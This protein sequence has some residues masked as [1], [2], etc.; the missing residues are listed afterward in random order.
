M[1]E[2]TTSFGYW[3]RRQR[4]ALDLTQR[5]LA[6]CVGCST[7]TIKKIEADERRPSVQMAKRLAV[8]LHI[9]AEQR[10]RFL[11]V[12][13]RERSPD[14]LPLAATPVPSPAALTISPHT[15]PTTRFIGRERELHA[16]EARL[17]QEGCRLLTVTGLGGVGKTRLALHAAAA[18]AHHFADGVCVVPLSDVE[19]ATE[20][21]AVVL[22]RLGLPLLGE[23]EPLA[24]LVHA[25][26]RRQL[27]LVLDNGE[28]LVAD[29]ATPRLLRH[30]LAAAPGV[31]LLVTSRERLN[32]QEEWM[33]PLEGLAPSEAAVALFVDRAGQAGRAVPP[34]SHAAVAAICRVVE[35]LPLAVELAAG[36]TRLLTPE[37]IATQLQAT[38]DLLQT[39]LRD[40]PERHR[41]LDALFDQSWALLPVEEQAIWTRLAVFRGGFDGDAAARVAGADLPALLSLVDKSL[42]RADGSG[43]YDLHALARRYAVRR[44]AAAGATAAARQQHA[45]YYFALLQRVAEQGHTLPL[46]RW[47]EWIEAEHANIRAAWQWGL[48]AG[49]WATLWSAVRP[50]FAFWMRRGSWSEGID[51]LLPAVQQAP[52]NDF[53]PYAETLI[54][55]ATLYART[56]HVEEALPYGHEGYRRALR[57]AH[58]RTIAM[59]EM[60]FMAMQAPEA[61]AREVHFQAALAASRQANDHQLLANAL[62][63]YGDFLREQGAL[64]RARA[65]YAECQSHARATR[66]DGLWLYAFGNEGRLALLDGDIDQAAA[67][68]GE[69]VTMARAQGNPV[70][71]ADWLLRLG[72]VQ[73]YQH[74][75]SAAHLTL[76]ECVE[77]AEE[78]SHQHC[79]T[80]AQLWLA[81]AALEQGDRAAAQDSL[82]LS[83]AEYR[84]RLE[85]P[86][87]AHP[88]VAEQ[89]E[90]LVVASRVYGDQVG[91][92]EA[93]M[94]LGCAEALAAQPQAHVDPFLAALAERAHARL[95][96]TMDQA[97]LEESLA[98]G[99]ATS[100]LA[101]L[102]A[103]MR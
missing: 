83:V 62:L 51:L 87:S 103:L 57:A 54:A 95:A 22:R 89:I 68:F 94:A 71:L 16:I 14:V 2:T 75:P 64:E 70:A 84:R 43:R 46:E 26:R 35:G 65:C 81:A 86:A 19:Q 42:V 37:Q 18:L 99:R 98:H 25:L 91:S 17:T 48:E 55:L 23:V 90:A 13:Q 33:L 38:P 69:C 72:V 15:A 52:P 12:A 30:L 20:V 78:L 80:N 59:A 88:S 53:G 32:L 66:D 61:S 101:C 79:L 73:F 77:L 49:Q 63:L 58:P 93:A 31:T 10:E 102:A 28:H 39:R 11:E 29:P 7:A 8:C 3:V 60:Y 100:A 56:G 34:G 45:D 92:E 44:L 24:Q 6:D 27:L 21:A 5:T 67:R 9:A 47:R 96:R 1:D 36:W 4:R 97:A 41:S 74:E 50:L 82:Q 76:T 85:S 40:V